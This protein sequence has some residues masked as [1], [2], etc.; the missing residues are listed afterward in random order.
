M[1]IK[2]QFEESLDKK[3][4]IKHLL[5]MPLLGLG[6]YQGYRG[7][8]W[9]KNRIIILKQFV[10]P[11]LQAQTNKDFT[12]WISVRPEDKK[13]KQIQELQEY[14]KTVK[15]FKTV[16]SFA[17]VCF[18]DDKYTDEIARDRLLTSLHNTMG[19]MTAVIGECDYVYMTI[20]PSDDCYS[21]DTIQKIQN[22][23]N[24]TKLEAVGYEQGYICDYLTKEIAEYN[25]NTNPPFFTIKFPRD[26]FI[27]ALK[28]IEY[29]GPYKSHEYLG[30]KLKCAIMDE[31]GFIVGV[32]GENISTH[33]NHPF[34]GEKVSQNILKDF[35]IYDVPVLKLKFSLRKKI[36]NKL[37]HKVRR[38][39]RYW[40]SERF[41][42]WLRK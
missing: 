39:L 36:L 7:S 22:I 33:F 6:L 4:K 41:Y 13:D 21:N 9:L 31:R 32:H 2:R 18:W 23:F 25:P 29:T 14:F 26:M 20:Q 37:P 5:Y 38:K 1:D 8:R 30:D 42:N 34:K 15:E 17:G 40:W 11:S 3:M 10:I 24:Q 16:F 28:H 27:D 12:L 35:G 19:E